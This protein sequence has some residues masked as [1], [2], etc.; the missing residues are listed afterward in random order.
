MIKKQVAISLLL[1]VIAIRKLMQSLIKNLK[2]DPYV[3][4]V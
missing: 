2:Q 1:H 4:M 3:K